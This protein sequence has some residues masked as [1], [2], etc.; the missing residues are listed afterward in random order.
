MKQ[1]EYGFYSVE[2][3]VEALTRTP[4][5]V[6]RRYSRPVDLRRKDSV[7]LFKIMRKGPPEMCDHW[8]SVHGQG[9]S[10]RTRL[11]ASHVVH[12]TLDGCEDFDALIATLETIN[13]L[14]K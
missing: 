5:A 13:Q 11:Y 14:N 12:Q 4:V 6:V 9:S 8:Y 1:N 3:C 2:D 7:T 10:Q